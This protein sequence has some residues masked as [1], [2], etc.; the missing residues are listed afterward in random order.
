MDLNVIFEDN[1]LIVINKQAGTLVQGDETGDEPL[2]DLVKSYIKTKYNKPGD[3]FLGTVHRLD[4]PTSGIVLFAKTSKALTRMN[5]LFKTKDIQ[6]TYWA[7]TEKEPA[8]K[9]GVCVDYLVKNEKQNKS[10]VKSEK[11]PGA[12]RAEL[13][14]RLVGKGE[15]YS[16]IEVNPATGRHHQIRVQLSTIGCIIK[17]DLK[18]GAKRS[19]KDGSISLHARKLVFKHPVKGE[20]VEIIAN[21]PDDP[22]WNAFLKLSLSHSV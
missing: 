13:S 9:N 21:P 12:K 17:G 19:N 5:E 18:Y 2:S 11:T 1:H 3:V 8:K 22:V 20:M 7:I 14:Y 10:S 4:R 15:N 6:K 16:F